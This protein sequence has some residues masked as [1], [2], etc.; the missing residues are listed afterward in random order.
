MKNKNEILGTIKLAPSGID[1]VVTN[2]GGAFDYCEMRTA[3]LAALTTI[4]Y[5]EGYETFKLHN[6][7]IQSNVLWLVN[8]LATEVNKL[9]PIVYLEA[10]KQAVANSKKNQGAQHE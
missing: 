7:D 4:I 6:E 3:Q 9:L 5:G 2:E 10:E 8:E 1:L